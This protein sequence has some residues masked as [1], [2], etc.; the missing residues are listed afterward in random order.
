MK[1]LGNQN[2]IKLIEKL[3]TKNQFPNSLILIG[4]KGIGKSLIAKNIALCLTNSISL[5]ELEII[6]N[7]SNQ[8]I[9]VISKEFRDEKKQNKQLIYRDDIAHINEFFKT[10]S[11]K[12]VKRVCVI[13]SVDDLSVDGINS[14]L[15]IIE[16]PKNNN[17]FILISHENKKLLPTIISRSFTVKLNNFNKNDYIS[18]INEIDD[19]KTN[20]HSYLYELTRGSIHISR[21]FINN[22]FRDIDDHLEKVLEVKENIKANTAYHYINFLNDKGGEKELIVSFFDYLILKNSLFIKNRINSLRTAK[23]DHFIAVID[24][25]RKLKERYITF[26][27]SYEHILIH[28]FNRLKQQ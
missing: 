10:K 9:L 4:Q 19:L 23:I 14:L 5:N 13:D 16:E 17:H 1:I 20:N 27:I 11:E 18:L 25:L 21:S 8:N 26:N 3:I 24:E 12:N 15:K 22:D 2:K 7:Q 6:N 28:Y